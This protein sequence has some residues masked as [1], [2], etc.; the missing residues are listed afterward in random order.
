MG[1]SKGYLLKVPK[2]VTRILHEASRRIGG[3]EA[4]LWLPTIGVNRQDRVITVYNT[5]CAPVQHTS[6]THV[7]ILNTSPAELSQ[8]TGQ[9]CLPPIG[10]IHIHP[11]NMPVFS[12]TDMK[13]LNPFYN[14]SILVS[15]SGESGAPV[16]SALY[17]RGEGVVPFKADMYED[18]LSEEK[19]RE[20]VDLLVK[21]VAIGDMEIRDYMRRYS[22]YDQFNM[23]RK[24]DGWGSV[25]LM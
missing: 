7:D 11:F 15:L 6:H 9:K 23:K 4:A 13:K 3:R 5:Y 8:K 16:V 14:Y 19:I 18:G 20:Y 10:V 17:V 1:Q 22:V 2:S 25:T 21:A 12:V 24:Y